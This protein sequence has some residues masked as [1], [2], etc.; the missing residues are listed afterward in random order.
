MTSAIVVVVVVAEVLLWPA[1]VINMA[2]VVGL[3]YMR[4]DVAIE[5]LADVETILVAAVVSA[6]GFVLP[7][8]YLADVLSDMVVDVLIDAVT[9]VGVVTG[10]GV[11]V[12]ADA[13]ANIFASLMTA[14][15]FPVPNPLREFSCWAA[16]GC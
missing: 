8:L 5:T 2:V 7:I 1:A 11:K 6:L 10:I 14:L 4:T 15:E 12:S 9:D 3:L 13:N 16:F